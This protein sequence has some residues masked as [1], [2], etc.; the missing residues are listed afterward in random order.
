[1]NFKRG[2]KRLERLSV[3]IKRA[4]TRLKARRA[5]KNKK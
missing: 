1:M 3:V 5:L 2:E 4:E